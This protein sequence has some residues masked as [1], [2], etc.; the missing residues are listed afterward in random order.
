MESDYSSR[1]LLSTSFRLFDGGHEVRAEKRAT[2]NTTMPMNRSSLT[3]AQHA[4]FRAYPPRN[5]LQESAV[6]AAPPPVRPKSIS[7]AETTQSLTRNKV[8]PPKSAAGFLLIDSSLNPIWFNAEALQIL[9]YPDKLANLRHSDVSL[10]GKIRLSLISQ[11][12]S[13]KSPFV[14]EL[15]SG[16]RRYFCRAFLVDSQAKNPAH[17]SIAILLERGP[18][19]LVALSQVS[20]K[21]NLTQREREVLEY[22]LQGLST[23]EIA[24]R[25]NVS[26]N[27]VK[28]FLRLIMIKAGVSSRSTIV[29]KI[30]VIQRH[31][32]RDVS[33]SMWSR[34]IPSTAPIRAERKACG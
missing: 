17:P 18:S 12:P 5:A 24:N 28:A 1:K 15:R 2:R 29:A 11:E 30:V 32:K 14:T 31:L 13:G 34:S 9:R 8:P 19:G 27:T 4:N 33:A 21:F 3:V 20:Q 22:L 26:P 23:K 7:A 10:T 16:R 6:R 25:M